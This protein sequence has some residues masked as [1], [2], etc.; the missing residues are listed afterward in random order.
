MTAPL[1][2]T[3]DQ[4]VQRAPATGSMQPIHGVSAR[5][6]FIPTLTAI[7]LLRDTG[8][9]PVSAEQSPVR[10]KD[11]DGYQKHMIRF[12]KNNKE[13]TAERVDLVLY[14]SHDRGCAFRLIASVWRKVCGNGLMVA[15][16]FANFSHKHIGFSPDAFMHSAREIASSAGIIADQVK[17]MRSI[18]LTEDERT[19]YAEAA[20]LLRYEN[21]DPDK[22]PVQPYQLLEERRYD[23]EGKDLWTTFN[24]VQE[25]IMR[26]GLQGVT[27]GTNGTRRR[28]KTRPI[29]SLDKNIR[30]NQSLWFLTEKM[31]EL[32][33]GSAGY[34][35]E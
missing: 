10:K 26:G 23:D 33:D 35:F 17:M 34:S 24:V 13:T 6:S 30:L 31:A 27:I 25:N 2:L 22:T 19:L 12:V 8:W 20:H 14:N 5:Y 21:R 18:E 16:E 1:L 3:N 32:K 4:I 9:F 7:D 29:T 15:S 11:R 28:Q